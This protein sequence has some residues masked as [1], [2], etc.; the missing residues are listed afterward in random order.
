MNYEQVAIIIP[1]YNE[2]ENILLLIKSLSSVVPG[3]SLFV[4]DD[5]SP[6][7]TARTVERR[8]GSS[9]H[10]Q[11]MRGAAKQGRGAAVIRGFRLAYKSST[12]RIF[13][14][15]DA[16][17]SHQPE[18][19]PKLLEQVTKKT[20]VCASRYLPGGGIV[21]WS[22]LRSLFSR[23]SNVMIRLVLSS[24]LSDNTNGF[25]AYPRAA[26]KKL[27]E[28]PL[29]TANY[30]VLSETTLLLTSQGFYYR[31]VPSYFPNR[32]VG[33][34]NTT[35]KLAVQSCLDLCRLWL[36]YRQRWI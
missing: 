17:H 12:Y 24:K 15:M 2:S 6:D 10:I 34:S 19:L 26:I 11:V 18:L 27:L 29:V 35:P 31:E 23:V 32:L 16:D 22:G 13:I 9:K 28:Q 25:R 21:G 30:L 20:V 7:G 5:N 36:H 8:Y 4:V 14:E 33:R 3:A 1:T